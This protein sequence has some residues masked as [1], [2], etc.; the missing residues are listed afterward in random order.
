MVLDGTY[1]APA[2]LSSSDSEA[3]DGE[4]IQE[5]AEMDP[6]GDQAAQ[7]SLEVE[8][9]EGQAME[10]QPNEEPKP[11]SDSVSGGWLSVVNR[12]VAELGS[13]KERMKGV[14][15]RE[16]LHLNLSAVG[17]Q[18]IWADGTALVQNQD[19][20]E[21]TPYASNFVRKVLMKVKEG[22]KAGQEQSKFFCMLCITK[23]EGPIG[24]RKTCFFSGP[25]LG[26]VWR[27]LKVHH[28]EIAA[29]EG[30]KAA[31]KAVAEAWEQHQSGGKGGRQGKATAGALQKYFTAAKPTRPGITISEERL[32]FLMYK[33]WSSSS[34]PMLDIANPYLQTL[35]KELL[36]A[37]CMFRLPKS[38]QGWINRWKAAAAEEEQFLKGIVGNGQPVSLQF[39]IWSRK[40]ASQSLMGACWNVW[41]NGV[42][43]DSVVAGVYKLKQPHT[44]ATIAD[45]VQMIMR[46]WGVDE[47]NLI[48]IVT[49]GASNIKAAL[50]D[51]TRRDFSDKFT[52]DVAFNKMVQDLEAE[53]E[54][55]EGGGEGKEDGDLQRDQSGLGEAPEQLDEVEFLPELASTPN[56][57]LHI[58][59]RNVGVQL[60]CVSHL[61]SLIGNAAAASDAR[62]VSLQDAVGAVVA[63]FHK[64]PKL[65]EQLIQESGLSLRSISRTRWVYWVP[66]FERFLRVRQFLAP[67]LEQLNEKREQ[68][69]N[70]HW[71]RLQDAIDVSLPFFRS[72]D[73]LGGRYYCTAP[74]VLLNF[75][76]IQEQMLTLVSAGDTVFVQFCNTA[77]EQIQDRFKRFLPG[78]DEE[79]AE[80]PWWLAAAAAD[81]HNS[82]GLQHFGLLSAAASELLNFLLSHLPTKY[83]ASLVEAEAEAEVEADITTPV[84]NAA[85]FPWL[86][87]KSAHTAPKRLRLGVAEQ[88]NPLYTKY[89]TEA[90]N[91]ISLLED[92]GLAMPADVQKSESAVKNRCATFWEGPHGFQSIKPVIV[93]LL[94]PQASS[95]MTERCFSLGSDL[96]SRKKS[97][98]G[99]ELLHFRLLSRMND[100]FLCRHFKQRL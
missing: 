77:A 30:H 47:G 18:D 89:M 73:V 99:A 63:A 42:G 21:Q 79:R 90:K 87:S 60:H 6:V 44:A 23:T 97:A 33:F 35:I 86:N 98:T 81:P 54:G 5:S 36:P 24:D 31:V 7:E 50:K 94:I 67:L 46:E 25:S 40:N 82:D 56:P 49:D 95:A 57:S 16:G 59:S 26:H 1:E 32:R 93:K 72:A 3:A 69:I 11:D 55:G 12:A 80:D 51:K 64:S 20:K 92:G 8:P 17:W 41:V 70:V 88:L 65:H 96:T 2:S 68:R 29:H 83:T 61:S 62:L 28:E 27:H 85:A 66:V 53:E 38:T 34:I 22:K 13:A 76:F 48:R 19:W 45:F 37:D 39:D 14:E 4:A 100:D 74:L 78:A 71:N 58:G 10:V 84:T 43:P 75:L 52:A 91:Y 15:A 9:V